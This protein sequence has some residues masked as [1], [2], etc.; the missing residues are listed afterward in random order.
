MYNWVVNISYA[1]LHH[2]TSSSQSPAL[3]KLVLHEEPWSFTGQVLVS[4]VKK[5]KRQTNRNLPCHSDQA[6]ENQAAGALNIHGN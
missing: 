4:L 2:F 1:L 5:E 6:A 3:Q